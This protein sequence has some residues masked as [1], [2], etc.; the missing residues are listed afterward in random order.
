MPASIDLTHQT[1]EGIL[2]GC[3]S[4][5]ERERERSWIGNLVMRGNDTMYN[6]QCRVVE[7]EKVSSSE[8]I[9]RLSSWR[10]ISSSL[11]PSSPSTIEWI[12]I[13]IS[14]LIGLS[15][16]LVSVDARHLN[17]KCWCGFVTWRHFTL[18]LSWCESKVSETQKLAVSSNWWYTKI[19]FLVASQQLHVFLPLPSCTHGIVLPVFYSFLSF[20]LYYHHRKV[21]TTWLS[22][23]SKLA[24]DDKGDHKTSGD[25]HLLCRES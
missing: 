11:H 12:E 10:M 20:Q 8:K 23:S 2:K 22:L 18:L 16:W 25:D 1:Q 21:F 17:R 5:V 14:D 6:V 15:C 13:M 9:F 24:R 3:Q 7:K 4:F 19:S